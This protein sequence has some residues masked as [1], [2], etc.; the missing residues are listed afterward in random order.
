M[1]SKFRP[2]SDAEEAAINAG[3]AADP[4]APE[5]TSD[6]IKKMRPFHEVFAGRNLGG[7]PRVERPKEPVSI[8]LDHDILSAFRETGAGWQ[9]RMNDAPRSEF[10][11]A[12][13]RQIFQRATGRWLR[14]F[15]T[16]LACS[17]ITTSKKTPRM[18]D[19]Q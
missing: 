14:R 2:I 4:D 19:C 10:T 1:K 13:T 8:R 7:R 15:M 9:T 11:A 6:Q 17:T 18:T 16:T 5:L 12:A 3:I